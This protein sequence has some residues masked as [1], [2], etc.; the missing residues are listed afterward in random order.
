MTTVQEGVTT[1]IIPETKKKYF[2]I[3]LSEQLDQF[4][5]TPLLNIS[6]M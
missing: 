5:G 1:L 4:C 6:K 3:K 2:L